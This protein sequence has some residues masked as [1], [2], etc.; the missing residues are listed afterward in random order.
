[1]KFLNRG[2]LIRVPQDVQL[3]RDHKI[4]GVVQLEHLKLTKQRYGLFNQKLSYGLAEIIIDG[5]AW[6]VDI[7][8]I[9]EGEI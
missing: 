8:D 9:F 4:D 5:Q 6:N 2:D 7:D 1:M 3:W